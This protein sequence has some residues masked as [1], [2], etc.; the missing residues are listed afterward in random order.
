MADP[1]R[2]PKPAEPAPEP[3]APPA[4]KLAPAAASGDAGVQWL[5][6]ERSTHTSNGDTAKL[7]EIDARLAELGFTAQ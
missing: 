2:A 3:T 5:L 1:K 6:A 4:P 7:A